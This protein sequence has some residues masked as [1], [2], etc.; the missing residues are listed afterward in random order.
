MPTQNTIRVLIA[1][2]HALVRD[3]LAMMLAE[4]PDLQV[5]GEAADGAE[6]ISAARELQPHV[7]LMDV[8]MPRVDGIAATAEICRDTTAKVLVLTTFD[9]DKH[10]Y[11]ALRAGASGFLLKDMRR[12]ELVE[13]VRV[14]SAG[15]SLL[16]PT[17]TRRLIGDVVGRSRPAARRADDGRLAALTARELETLRQVARGLSNAEIAAELFVTE[18]TVKTHVSSVLAKLGLRDRVQVVVLAYESGLV[19]PRSQE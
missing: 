13:A 4:Q 14:V 18:H 10:V 11:D 12:A 2:D 3:G 5:V 8:R 9:L 7:V 16:A 6:A 1:D 15:E 17:V 19:T